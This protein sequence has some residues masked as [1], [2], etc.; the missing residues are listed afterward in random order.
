MADRRNWAI[1]RHSGRV[2]NIPQIHQRDQTFWEVMDSLYNEFQGA[3][4]NADLPK[5]L[6]LNGEPLVFPSRIET[7]NYNYQTC[8]RELLAQAVRQA[9]KEA[10]ENLPLDKFLPPE[11]V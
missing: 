6:M 9:Q 10:V 3:G 4:G 7:W 2:E 1:I 5:T 11:K 8:K